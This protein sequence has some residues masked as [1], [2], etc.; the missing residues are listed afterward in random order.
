MLSAAA[1]ADHQ[2][3]GTL[4]DAIWMGWGVRR[5]EAG[6]VG[7]DPP[8]VDLAEAVGVECFEA[9]DPAARS[10]VWMSR[11]TRLRCPRVA[12]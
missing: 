8:A 5:R 3:G 7:H 1:G 4:R 2:F 11:C 6:E 10:S 9:G 12:G